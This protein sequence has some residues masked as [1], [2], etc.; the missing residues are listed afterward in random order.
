MHT[1]LYHIRFDSLT[2]AQVAA[3]QLDGVTGV[4]VVGV[5]QGHSHGPEILVLRLEDGVTIEELANEAPALKLS[6]DWQA[7][8]MEAPD[9]GRVVPVMNPDEE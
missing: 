1:K 2:A 9:T 3:K 4:L 7:F 6:G 5:S 8:D